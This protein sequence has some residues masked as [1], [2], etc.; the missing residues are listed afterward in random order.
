[1]RTLLKTLL[2]CGLSLLPL[3]AFALDKAAV[4]KQ[5][6]GWIETEIWPQA[7]ASGVSRANFDAAF[8]GVTLNWD[9]P[10]L[11]PPGSKPPK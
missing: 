3:P 6:H 4:E 10:D 1:M 9:L 2:I 7:K 8:A 11:V 5:F